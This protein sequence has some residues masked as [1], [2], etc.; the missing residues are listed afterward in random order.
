MKTVL[1]LLSVIAILTIGGFVLL[2]RSRSQISPL[3]SPNPLSSQVQETVNTKASFTIITDSITRSFKAEKYHNKSPD[4]YIQADDP[5]VVHVK[6]ANITWNDF[7]KTLPMS[8][9]KDCLTTGDGETF[10]SGKE[11]QL[12]FFLNNIETPDLLEREIHPE[13]SILIKFT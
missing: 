9:T 2:G 4:V 6:K 8:L 3:P 13:D 10:C 11:G 1:P 7:F 12:E 5:T